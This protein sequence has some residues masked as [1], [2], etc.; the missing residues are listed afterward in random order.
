VFSEDG[1]GIG[2]GI[3]NPPENVILPVIVNPDIV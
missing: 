1:A 2:N 3:S